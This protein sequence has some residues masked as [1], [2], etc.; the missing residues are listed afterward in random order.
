MLTILG[1]PLA[2][3]FH[4]SST[5]YEWF[6]YILPWYVVNAFCSLWMAH[7]TLCSI[8]AIL[9]K[10]Y[11]YTHF[12]LI[13]TKF[14]WEWITLSHSQCHLYS[15]WKLIHT[16]HSWYIYA[17]YFY[18]ITDS[19]HLMCSTHVWITQSQ[20]TV[21]VVLVCTIRI[22]KT[23]SVHL[24]EFKSVWTTLSQSTVMRCM[25]VLCKMNTSPTTQSGMFRRLCSV[26]I[27]S[28]RFTQRWQYYF[29]S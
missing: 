10:R 11:S 16:V 6:I 8:C 15:L 12:R 29:K 9:T 7:P 1:T 5:K 28:N 25:Y 27:V 21:N 3:V 24:F 23:H 2:H 14:D 22:E 18:R 13:C 17:F 20:C 26:I 4:I 19:V